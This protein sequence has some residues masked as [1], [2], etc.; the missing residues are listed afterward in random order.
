MLVDII[1]YNTQAQNDK[2]VKLV[3]LNRTCERRFNARNVQMT[4]N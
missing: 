1:H 3:F 2:S 4:N